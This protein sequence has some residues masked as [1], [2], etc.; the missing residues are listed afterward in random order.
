MASKRT[1]FQLIESLVDKNSKVL[2]IGCADGELLERLTKNRNIDA[3]GLELS[4][5]GVNACVQKGL[6]VV[7][8]DA[9][10]DLASYPDKAF[11]F[12][13]LSHTLQATRNPRKVMEQLKRIG[14]K[15]IISI[16][17]FGYWKVR[18]SL[19]LRGRMPVTSF[20]ESQWYD[21]ENI[22]FCTI[23]DFVHLCEELNIR[24]ETSITLK[25]G[26][27]KTKKGAP[28]PHANLLAEQ[29]LFV[30]SEKP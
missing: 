4:Q 24:F 1:D 8:G 12:V 6:C 29:C 18:M 22:H 25:N 5:L 19:F 30:L 26:S 15:L 2:D 14:K 23:K 17:N 27:I 20:L 7:Q 21:T 11:D 28:P 16:P 10:S 9:D 13:I 3:R